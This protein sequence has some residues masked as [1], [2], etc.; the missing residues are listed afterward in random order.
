M[1]A[2][3]SF[4]KQVHRVIEH[5][6]MRDFRVMSGGQPLYCVC[7]SF[8]FHCQTGG[9]D[10]ID[11]MAVFWYGSFAFLDNK[12]PCWTGLLIVTELFAVVS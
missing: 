6:G 10:F 11:A 4:S 8:C 5:D 1:V 7:D 2:G 12:L 9:D 3:S